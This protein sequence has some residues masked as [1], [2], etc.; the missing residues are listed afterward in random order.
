MRVTEIEVSDTPHTEDE[1][2]KCMKKVGKANLKPVPYLFCNHN[3]KHHPDVSYLIGAPPGSAYRQYYLCAR[4]FRE[5]E[6]CR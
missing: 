2:D 6:K 5:D 1:C 3:D 4:C